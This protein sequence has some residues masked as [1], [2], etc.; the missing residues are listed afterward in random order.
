M[1]SRYVLREVCR[2]Q[3]RFTL[4]THG[5]QVLLN[6]GLYMDKDSALR[7]INATRSL[8]RSSR[9]YD[10]LT[11]QD[12][13]RYFMVVTR[14]GEALA[15]SATY[16]DAESRQAVIN[17]VKA[18]SR[19]A[20]LEI[21]TQNPAREQERPIPSGR[22]AARY[23]QSNK[24][25]PGRLPASRAHCVPTGLIAFRVEPAALLSSIDRGYSLTAAGIEEQSSK[26]ESNVG[27]IRPPERSGR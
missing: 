21:L 15:C 11:A 1:S 6:S 23:P 8:A 18:N 10:L 17:L 20:R 22:F 26:G 7:K 14:K 5:G 12:G 25:S 24:P 4:V 9:N 19:G 3:Y 16:P 27:R 2:G 13:G